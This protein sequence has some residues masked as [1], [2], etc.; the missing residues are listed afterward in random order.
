[1][2]TNSTGDVLRVDA[3]NFAS[4]NQHRTSRHLWSLPQQQQD[5]TLHGDF[6]PPH[7]SR[8]CGQRDGQLNQDRRLECLRRSDDGTRFL[9]D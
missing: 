9:S 2:D 3:S 5:T 1:M 6:K 4:T 7:E 8:G